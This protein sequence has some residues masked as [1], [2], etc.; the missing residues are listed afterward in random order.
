MWYINGR[1]ESLPLTDMRY[2]NGWVESLVLRRKA[3]DFFHISAERM[4]Q[5]KKTG[6][7]IIK[8]K[9]FDDMPDPYLKGNKAGNRPHYYCFEDTATGIYWMIPLVIRQIKRCRFRQIKT[10]LSEHLTMG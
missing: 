8:D 9:F 3:R 1:V 7:Y 10:G 2:I 6:F 5:M 4:E